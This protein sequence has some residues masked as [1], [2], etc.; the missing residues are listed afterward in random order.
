MKIEFLGASGVGKTTVAKKVSL[1]Y[2]DAGRRVFWPRY[3]LYERISWKKRNIIKIFYVAGYAL[4]HPIGTIN[5]IMNIK[6]C[7]MVKKDTTNIIY[8][9]IFLKKMEQ[10]GTD[11]DILIFDEGSL[12]LV[13]SILRRIKSDISDEFILYIISFFKLP[14]KIVVV[15]ADTAVIKKRLLER[16]KYTPLLDASDIEEEIDR[17]RFEQNIIINNLIKNDIIDRKNVLFFENN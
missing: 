13:W 6:K 3:T 2:K 8:N 7:D 1:I 9:G 15:D 17:M 4:M 16:G 14:D 11:N 10:T 5:L 12:Q